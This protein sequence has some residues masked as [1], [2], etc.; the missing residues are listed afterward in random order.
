MNSITK[1][2]LAPIGGTYLFLKTCGILKRVIFGKKINDLKRKFNFVSNIN[3]DDISYDY[4]F[5][6]ADN[7]NKE[8]YLFVV[9]INELGDTKSS[10]LSLDENNDNNL[11]HISKIV[12]FI[13]L[14]IKPEEEIIFNI[15]SPGGSVIEYF[16]AYNHLKRLKDKGYKFNVFIKKIAASGGYLISSLAEK[17]YATNEAYIGSVGVYTGDFNFSDLLNFL[18]IKYKLYKSGENKNMGDPYDVPNEE[19]DKKIQKDIE[20]THERFKKVVLENRKNVD[21]EKV[22]TADTWFADEA[23]QIGLVDEIGN[24]NDYLLE[25]AKKNIIKEIYYKNNEKQSGGLFNLIAKLMQ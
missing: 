10:F 3:I 25:R 13:L 12:D 15:D 9:N 16:Y 8:K 23:K 5:C 21:M 20:N 2:L 24:V 6:I 22:K 1:Y 14:N 17:I 4:G 18:K 11:K 7:K 19:A